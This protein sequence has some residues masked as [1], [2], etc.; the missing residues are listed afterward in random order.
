MMD[1]VVKG[2]MDSGMNDRNFNSHSYIY[3]LYF[4]LQ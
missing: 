1:Y 4:H 3:A 2:P